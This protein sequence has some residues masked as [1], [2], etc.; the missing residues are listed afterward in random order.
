MI[1]ALVLLFTIVILGL[2]AALVLIPWAMI[3]GN[4]TPL[5]NAAIRTVR[6]AFRLAGIRVETTGLERV[7]PRILK[8]AVQVHGGAFASRSQMRSHAA[9]RS[10]GGFDCSAGRAPVRL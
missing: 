2:P 8:R 7:P 5:Y 6:M 4:A 10:H 1:A 9:V 3:T